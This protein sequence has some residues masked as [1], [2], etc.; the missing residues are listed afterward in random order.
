[1]LILPHS[2][3]MIDHQSSSSNNLGYLYIGLGFFLICFIDELISLYKKTRTIRT[4][5]EQ[6]NESKQTNYLLRLITLIAALSIH[7][8]FSKDIF[9]CRFKLK[10]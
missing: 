1:M 3:S 6:F 7:Y 2:L 4:Q 5:D 8:F 9:H 10:T